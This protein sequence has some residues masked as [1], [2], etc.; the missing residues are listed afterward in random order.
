[1]RIL[2][3][4]AREFILT[5]SAFGGGKQSDPL[6]LAARSG[7]TIAPLRTNEASMPRQTGEPFL[8]F[9][10]DLVESLD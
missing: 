8:V 6:Q 2:T 3:M 9:V 4:E 7:L 10:C 5:D 1:M